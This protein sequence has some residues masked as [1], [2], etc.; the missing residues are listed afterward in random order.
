VSAE[1]HRSFACFGGTV[2]VHVRGTSSASGEEAADRAQER[3]LDAHRRLSRF[4]EESELSRVNRDPREEVPASPLMR[5]LASA[6]AGAG[7]SSEGLVDATLLDAIERAGYRQSLGDHRPIELTEALAGRVGRRPG[8]PHPSARWRSVGVDEAAG[9]IVR[10]PGLKIDSGGIAK[11]LLADLLAADLG[12]Q[13]AFAIDCCGDV[14]IGGSA[15]LARRVLVDD[16]FGGAPIHELKLR[17]GAAAT[18]GIGR[19]C[20]VGADGKVAHHVL[21][22]STGEPA[23]TGIV[24]ATALAPSALLAETYAKAALL[25]GPERAAEWLPH[26]GVVVRDGGEVDLLVGDRPLT[27]IAVAA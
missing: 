3:L 25:S 24:Q 5:A 14:H 10:P 8:R 9:T 6:V 2:T 21:D 26:G 17:N 16:P 20:W 4:R 7:S 15:R 13:R 22:P 11:G 19:R 23:F 1:A 27:E 18:S 12:E